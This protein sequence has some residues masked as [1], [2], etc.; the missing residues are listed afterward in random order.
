MELV[1]A[2]FSQ[3]RAVQRLPDEIN[4]CEIYGNWAGLGARDDHNKSISRL[5]LV[6]SLR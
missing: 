2:Q 5:A 3:Q 6:L 4:V 1:S